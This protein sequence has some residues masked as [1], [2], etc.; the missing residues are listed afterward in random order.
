MEILNHLGRI[1][2]VMCAEKRKTL[3]SL[4][5]FIC[6]NAETY[7]EI[8]SLV[9]T[10]LGHSTVLSKNWYQTKPDLFCSFEVQSRLIN[11]NRYKSINHAT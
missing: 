4:I 3:E 10:E 2:D 1:A 11:A 9:H 6:F 7:F 5:P 8:V